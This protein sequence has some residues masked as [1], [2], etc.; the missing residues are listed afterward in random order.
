MLTDKS[1]ISNSFAI[2][3]LEQPPTAEKAP[4]VRPR[5]GSLSSLGSASIKGAALHFI[6]SQDE[7]DDVVATYCGKIFLRIIGSRE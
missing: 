5:A 2:A 1:A 3:L 4:S 7:W 6:S